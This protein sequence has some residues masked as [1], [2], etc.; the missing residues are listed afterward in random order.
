[1]YS[2]FTRIFHLSKVGI[3]NS[4]YFLNSA[5]GV[6]ASDRNPGHRNDSIT[7]NTRIVSVSY[8]F[9]YILSA[10]V[11]QKY[12]EMERRTHRFD[13]P[14]FSHRVENRI[15]HHIIVKFTYH[16]RMLIKL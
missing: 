13:Q 11:N 3:E 15:Y 4:R 10:V 2:P 6:I 16:L 7:L 8:V 14:H 12:Y 1:M 9:L 5:S